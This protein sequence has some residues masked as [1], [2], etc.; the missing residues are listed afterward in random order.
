LVAPV[1]HVDGFLS[2]KGVV[3]VKSYATYVITLYGGICKDI[4]TWFPDTRNSMDMDLSYLRRAFEERGLPFFLQT[5][6]DFGHWIDRSLDQ[7]ALISN[8]SIPRGIPSRRGRPR[9]F[10]GVLNKV[11]D[12]SGVLRTDAD[13][14]AVFFLR[15]L[16]QSFKKLEVPVSPSKLKKTLK[17]FFDVEEHLPRSHVDTWDS[18]VPVWQDR[19]GHPLHGISSS[20]GN[21]LNLLDVG[22]WSYDHRVPWW[23]LRLL[24]RRVIS[25]IGDCNPWDLIP[26]HGP[27]AVSEAGKGFKWAFP[28]WPR[29]LEAIFPYDWHV[30]GDF[31]SR[32]RPPDREESSRL[33]A[34]P[35]T[36]KGPRLICAEPTAHQYIQQGIWNWLDDRIRA[37]TLGACIDF[38][39]QEESQKMA[40]LASHSGLLAT[41]DLSAASDRLSTR[42]VEYI[43]QGSNLL[44]MFHACRTRSV[45]QTLDMKLPKLHILRKFATMGSAL[46]F[47]VQTI[48]FAIL[49]CW[50]LRLAEGRWDDWSN[51]KSDFGRIRVFGDDII[52]PTH[53]YGITKLVLHE[54]GLLVN[55]NKSF[56]GSHFR[57]SC[58]MDAFNGVDVT[59]AR[60]RLPYDGSASSTAALVEYSNNLYKKG[61]WNASDKAFGLIPASERKLIPV[62]GPDD[63]VALGR[64]SYQNGVPHR[65]RRRWDPNL[66]RHY[67]VCLSFSSKQRSTDVQGSPRLSQYFTE[68]L[69]RRRGRNLPIQG[70]RPQGLETCAT[71]RLQGFNPLGTV[72]W[73]EILYPLPY[74][75]GKSEVDRLRKHRSRAYLGE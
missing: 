51:W 50:A 55:S 20:R 7:G 3:A 40:L 61:M 16:C 53:A 37:T 9:L 72:S 22:S 65:Q 26:R 75:G 23:S 8:E 69:L 14:R 64:V 68:F 36:F 63:E 60:H 35:K 45:K 38:A 56:G 18:D 29:K 66:Q 42:L 25:E 28:N 15:T 24:C 54:C 43:F 49:S 31:D 19:I 17:E 39:S 21:Q 27:G 52:V 11:F 62:T 32:E 70:S 71:N 46:T 13:A 41:L 57:E 4:T 48:V 44:D 59:P 33:I 67:Y 12:T 58:G 47:P 73:R 30:T 34:V 1:S 2:F 74:E 10:W 5:L 6:P